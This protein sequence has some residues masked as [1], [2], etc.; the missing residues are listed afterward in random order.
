M[1]KLQSTVTFLGPI[2]TK[3]GV[4]SRVERDLLAIKGVWAPSVRCGSTLVMLRGAQTWNQDLA[5][6]RRLLER[7]LWSRPAPPKPGWGIR[8]VEHVSQIYPS[9]VLLEMV[10]RLIE[11]NGSSVTIHGDA[12]AANLVRYPVLGVRWIDPLDRPYVPGDPAV[13]LGKMLQSCWNY[14]GALRGEHVWRDVVTETEVLHG[15]DPATQA[16]ARMWSLVHMARLLRYHTSDVR[17]K[18][19]EVLR[20]HGCVVS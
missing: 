3:T 16:R 5:D 12:T 2:V 17:D 8:L 14:E 1:G 20:Y 4:A 10:A 15:I 18:F 13:D 19:V 9:P 11:W 6:G 7:R